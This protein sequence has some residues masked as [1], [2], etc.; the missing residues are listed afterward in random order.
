[1]C[2]YGTEPIRQTANLN[3]IIS[4]NRF[5]LEMRNEVMGYPDK[6]K[7]D[8]FEVDCGYKGWT[9]PKMKEP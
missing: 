8:K 9:I 6:R 2:N 5:F 1:M 4:K 3:N 7:Y